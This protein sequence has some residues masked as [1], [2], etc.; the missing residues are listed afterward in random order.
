MSRIRLKVNFRAEVNGFEFRIFLLDEL[1]KQ[2]DRA[3]S[4]LLFTL[5]WWENS[6]CISFLG[7]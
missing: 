4:V 7:Y 2:V 3:Q 1:P 5:S 6:R